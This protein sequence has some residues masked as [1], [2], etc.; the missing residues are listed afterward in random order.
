MLRSGE[1]E[2]ARKLIFNP[3][4]ERDAN[5]RRIVKGNPTNIIELNNVKYGWAFELYRTMGFSNFWIPA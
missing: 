1:R 4:G 3:Q 5:R 2:L